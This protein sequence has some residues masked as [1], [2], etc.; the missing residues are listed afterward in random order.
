MAHMVWKGVR[1]ARKFKLT[2]GAEGRVVWGAGK[3]S[4]DPAFESGMKQ[5]TW[6]SGTDSSN[7]AFTWDFVSSEGPTEAVEPTKRP[8]KE[9]KGKGTEAGKGKGTEAGKGK[10][11]GEGKGR[12]KGLGAVF[13]AV[14]GKAK[15]KGKGLED[16][17]S[18]G[19]GKAGK[20]KAE[21]ALEKGK[22]GK[23]GKAKG[24]A[25]GGKGKSQGQRGGFVQEAGL[26]RLCGA[27]WEA[28]GFLISNVDV[29][30]S[31]EGRP[32]FA[33]LVNVILPP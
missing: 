24:D 18:K 15:G 16:G 6:L 5:V 23:A 27:D 1:R 7:V 13:A 19:K 3:F 11:K 25:K 26:G 20:G 33:V 30:L 32:L 28:V 31:P 2:E 14:K 8:R 10:G 29:K 21:D 17:P 22:G 9:G 4:L 12:G